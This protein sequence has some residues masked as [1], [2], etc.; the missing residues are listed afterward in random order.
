MGL[1]VFRLGRGG[2]ACWLGLMG[3]FIS[4]WWKSLSLSENARAEAGYWKD[5][6]TGFFRGSLGII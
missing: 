2:W 5:R 6:L 1:L 4:R 3:M